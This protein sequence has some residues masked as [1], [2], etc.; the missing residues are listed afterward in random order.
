MYTSY[1][2]CTLHSQ[3]IP[4]IYYSISDLSDQAE[5]GTGARSSEQPRKPEESE[6]DTQT[7]AQLEQDPT[8]KSSASKL[9]RDGSV[10]I[11]LTSDLPAVQPNIDDPL[12]TSDTD[13]QHSASNIK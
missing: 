2:V 13:A 1:N 9:T 3:L 8:V 11:E 5:E 10:I 12:W 7:V 4:R 6:E